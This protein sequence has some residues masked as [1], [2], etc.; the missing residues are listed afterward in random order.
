MRLIEGI[1][2]QWDKIISKAVCSIASMLC[3]DPR[4]FRSGTEGFFPG[5]LGIFEQ[6]RVILAYHRQRI[7]LKTVLMRLD[8][9]SAQVLNFAWSTDTVKE[10]CQSLTPKNA[11]GYPVS[12]GFNA[13]RSEQIWSSYVCKGCIFEPLQAWKIE[14]GWRVHLLYHFRDCFEKT[15]GQF[16]GIGFIKIAQS[17]HWSKVSGTITKVIEFENHVVTLARVLKCLHFIDEVSFILEH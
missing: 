5:T 1:C 6:E 8:F 13:V 11:C 12:D 16:G 4:S 10:L 9:N 7:S 14:Y 3:E 15:S 2:I 17:L